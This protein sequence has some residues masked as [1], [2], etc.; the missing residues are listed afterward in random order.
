MTLS[1]SG[2]GITSAN[3]VDG[4]I[5]NADIN[6][7]AAIA[8]S[9]LSGVNAPE[10]TAVKST[11]EAG[12]TK[13][14]RED[15]DGTCSWQAAGATGMDDV[16]GVARATSGLLL[17]ADTAAANKLDD[18][19]EGTFTLSIQ[20]WSTATFSMGT[21][22]AAKYTK[23]GNMVTIWWNG[24]ISCTTSNPGDGDVKLSG[25]PFSTAGSVA[26]HV[27]V[28]T[29]STAILTYNPRFQFYGSAGYFYDHN[30]S[31]GSTPMAN[32]FLTST[33]VNLN[34][35]YMVS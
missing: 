27:P 7:S 32:V 33:R 26:I 18:Y 12:G 34:F 15:G 30:T 13:F 14:L 9:K 1:L 8:A 31:G 35:S 20:D 24:L 19:E 25:F 28:V 2:S 16:S 17:N 21:I 11:G 23:I 10:G 6:A 3:I 5:V 22:T 29:H 4:T